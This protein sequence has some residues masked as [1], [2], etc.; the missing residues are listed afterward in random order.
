MME[1]TPR[2]NSILLVSPT[3]NHDGNCIPPIQAD[4]NDSAGSFPGTKIDG[5]SRPVPIVD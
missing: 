4:S 3:Y 2:L 5:V 1:F